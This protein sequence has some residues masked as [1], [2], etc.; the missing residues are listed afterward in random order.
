MAALSISAT[1]ALSFALLLLLFPI[2]AKNYHTYVYIYIYIT[3]QPVTLVS[4]QNWSPLIRSINV[5]LASSDT[6]LNAPNI[7]IPS[8]IA[9]PA[10]GYEWKRGVVGGVVSSSSS[11]P[12]TDE[13]QRIPILYLSNIAANISA[14]ILDK[15]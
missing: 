9:N 3:R 8:P 14:V 12:L 6:P 13:F 1:V 5:Q 2:I 10:N 4:V 11:P 7:S 15:V